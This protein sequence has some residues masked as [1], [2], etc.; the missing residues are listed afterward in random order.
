MHKT[1]ALAVALFAAGLSTPAAAAPQAYQFDKAHTNILFFI[2]H[3]G[4]SKMMGEFRSFDGV[5]NFDPENPAASSVQVSIRVDGVSTDVKALDEHL[6]KPEFFNT[7]QFPAITFNSTAVAVVS[8]GKL[9]VTGDLT[10]LGVTKPVTLDVS[11]NK[12][13]PHP[14]TKAPAAGFS[15]TATL[16]RSDFGMSAMLGML[17]DDIEIRIETEAQAAK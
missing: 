15:A 14:F 16:K 8:P 6:Q 11:V 3:L 5:L 7:E 12:A 10:L 1:L 13:A 4:F 9:K 17:G 2:E